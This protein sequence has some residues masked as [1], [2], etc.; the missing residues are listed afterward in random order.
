MHL[1]VPKAFIRYVGNSLHPTDYKR[2]DAWVK[3]INNWLENGLTELYFFMH[4]HDEAFSPE[5]SVYL[6]EQ[7]N[8]ICNLNLKKPK[9]INENLLIK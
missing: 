7:L 3:Q 5:L 8:K 1:T 2:I 9:F 4:M 6:V